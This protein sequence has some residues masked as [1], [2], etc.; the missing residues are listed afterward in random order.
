MC[1]DSHEK[2]NYKQT[3]WDLLSHFSL[4]CSENGLSLAGVNSL[5]DSCG[6]GALIVSVCQACQLLDISVWIYFSVR[7]SMV[8]NV[9]TCKEGKTDNT[10]T[11]QY[12]KKHQTHNYS[13]RKI[14]LARGMYC[15]YQSSY[16]SIHNVF[17]SIRL[18]FSSD[19]CTVSLSQFNMCQSLDV[20]LVGSVQSYRR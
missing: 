12:I 9:K 7:Y 1:K 3:F 2:Q 6:D 20:S 17:Y 8:E 16:T 13:R 15:T 19:Y 14:P 10:S 4:S 5:S 11:V 18:Y